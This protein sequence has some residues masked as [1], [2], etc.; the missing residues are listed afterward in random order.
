MRGELEADNN[1]VWHKTAT[2]LP[3][4]LNNQ[5]IKIESVKLGLSYYRNIFYQ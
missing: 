4:P 3:N 1:E 2:W 5:Q